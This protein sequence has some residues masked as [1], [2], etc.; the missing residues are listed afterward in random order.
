[1]K[2]YKLIKTYP[3]SPKLNAIVDFDYSNRMYGTSVFDM[4][5]NKHTHWKEF[6][7]EVIEKDYEILS[8]RYSNNGLIYTY[9][10][11]FESTC[12][13]TRKTIK[14]WYTYKQGQIHKNAPEWG[15]IYRPDYEY[16]SKDGKVTIHSIK[17]LSDGEVFTVDDDCYWET[18][19]KTKGYFTICKFE[20]TNDKVIIHSNK[21]PECV[22]NNVIK[23]KKPVIINLNMEIILK[24]FLV[25]K[26]VENIF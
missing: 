14:G 1:M 3:G 22:L 23:A 25:K 18:P 6:W 20:I 26:N 13:I 17:R 5:E 24:D 8:V 11:N 19:D 21:N 9:D 12:H 10:A 4:E 7:R 15:N 2:K 16:K